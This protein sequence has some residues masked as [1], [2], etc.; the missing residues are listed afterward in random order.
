MS[1]G[2]NFFSALDDSDDDKE[3][4]TGKSEV[5]YAKTSP[6]NVIPTAETFKQNSFHGGRKLRNSDGGLTKND[7]CSFSRGSNYDRNKRTVR[8]R[9]PAFRQGKR[10]FDRRSGTGRGRE[11]KKGGVGSHNWGSEKYEACKVECDAITNFQVHDTVT[12]NSGVA[13]AEHRLVDDNVGEGESATQKEEKNKKMEGEENEM[14]TLTEFLKSRTCPDSEL[15]QPKVIK[16]VENEFIGKTARVTG[17]DDALIM[18]K[19]KNLRRKANKK[20]EKITLDVGFHTGKRIINN[21]KRNEQKHK[22]NESSGG[23]DCGDYRDSN[24]DKRHEH[25]VSM[26]PQMKLNAMDTSAFPSL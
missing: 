4:D 12:G 2:S 21:K 25:I 23:Y 14:M 22:H 6:V 9:Q 8:G 16:S 1:R 17:K 19:G 18:G 5:I 20:S 3:A 26:L 10:M 24:E 15:F 7:H 13:M 11:V